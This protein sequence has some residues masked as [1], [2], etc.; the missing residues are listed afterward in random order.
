M[1]ALC[2]MLTSYWGLGGSFF[3]NIFDKFN[4]GEEDRAPAKRRFMVLMVVTLPPF[5][6]AY[7]GL[8]SFVNA[9]YIAGTFSGVVLSIMPI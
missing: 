2:A 7:S 3:T 4:L 5:I 8:V 9:L 1:F 6:M